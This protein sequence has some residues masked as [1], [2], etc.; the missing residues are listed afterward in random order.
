MPANQRNHL[1]DVE[2]D[3]RG[4]NAEALEEGG[5]MGNWSLH[6]LAA[7]GDLESHR[8]AIVGEFG[9]PKGAG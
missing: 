1:S 3:H 6:W 2:A 9:R 4:D 5:R 7:T 8:A